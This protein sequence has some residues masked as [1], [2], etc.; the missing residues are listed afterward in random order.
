M[1]F[2]ACDLGGTKIL[3]GIYEKLNNSEIPKLILKEKYLSA[4]WESFESILEDFFYKRFKDLSI[5]NT[6]CFAV[7]GPIKNN[8]SKLAN[9]PWNISSDQIKNKFKLNNIELIN[10]FAVLIYGLPFLNKSQY[11]IIQNG[12]NNEFKNENL[13]TIVGAGTGL[14]ISRG[15]INS[16]NIEV[17]NSEGGHIEY[18]PKTSQEWELKFW[19]KNYLKLERISYE[20]VISGEGLC[21]IA[22]WRLSY[23]DAINHSFQKI[24]KESETSNEIKKILASEI[25]KFAEKGDPLLMEIESIW[26]K[27]YASY[28]GDVAIHELCFGGLWISGGT[29][30]KHFKNF[31]SNSFLKQFS[32]KGR[33]KDILK[34]IPVKVILDDEFGLFSAAC[35]AK[36]LLKKT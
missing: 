1:K 32:D 36:M 25:C 21:N 27:N 35:R 34:S 23:P 17:L 12:K 19:L 11:E 26:L 28:I 6:A 16:N 22:K 30:P 14:G 7:A 29:A 3:L 15:L 5:I 2:L 13:H 9:L 20:R 10:D 33:Y 4:E 8:S 24:I 31:K 18:A